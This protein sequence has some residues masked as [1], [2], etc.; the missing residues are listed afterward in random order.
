MNTRITIDLGQPRLLTLLKLT[1]AQTGKSIR[2]V[3]VEALEGYF[4]HRR[5]NQAILKMAEKTFAEWDNPK[6]SEYDKLPPR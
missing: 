5:E 6:D 1:A 3:V 2:E 4:S